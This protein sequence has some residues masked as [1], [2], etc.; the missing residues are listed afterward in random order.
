MLHR[1]QK[2]HIIEKKLKAKRSDFAISGTDIKKIYILRI[3]L[4]AKKSN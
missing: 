3:E 2:N 4:R 1:H